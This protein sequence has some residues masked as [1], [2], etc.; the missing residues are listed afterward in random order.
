MVSSNNQR[1]NYLKCKNLGIDYYIIQ[2]FESGE[3]YQIFTSVFPKLEEPPIKEGFVKKIQPDLKILYAEDNMMNQLTSK[4]IF[5]NLG[6]EI[7]LA[8]DGM[9]ALELIKK[10]KYDIVF[11]DLIMP[12][13]DGIATTLEIRNKIK[14]NLPIIGIGT[15]EQI[16]K[17]EEALS[18]G[19]DDFIM[20][21]VKIETIKQLL[22]NWFSIEI[23]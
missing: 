6:Y 9:K 17:K 18:V 23:K 22:L 16:N 7:D 21:P 2:P 14:T 13:M 20:K 15:D 10:N 3:I 8:G 5:K 4:A 11:M 12:G 1:G 19:M